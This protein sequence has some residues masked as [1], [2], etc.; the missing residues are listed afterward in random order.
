MTARDH[1]LD[2]DLDQLHVVL[3]SLR[4]A[5]GLDPKTIAEQAGIAPASLLAIERGTKTTRR[6]L[7]AIARA[8]GCEVQYRAELKL[9]K[10]P[11]AQ[12]QLIPPEPSPP[13]TQPVAPSGTGG[14]ADG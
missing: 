11:T 9:S 2:V 1:D 12:Q 8:L 3:A 6:T 14:P 5:Y 13:A 7:E 10:R 4:L